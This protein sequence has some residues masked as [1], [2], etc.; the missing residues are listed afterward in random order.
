[1]VRRCPHRERTRQ[2]LGTGRQLLFFTRCTVIAGSPNFTAV[3]E[4]PGVSDD[5]SVV[6]FYGEN[7]QGPGIFASVATP[8]GSW[9]LV[10]V[11]NGWANFYANS[12]IGVTS[13]QGSPQSFTAHLASIQFRT[14]SRLFPAAREALRFRQTT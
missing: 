4:A 1:M 9:T 11:A 3:G 2:K 12:P 13:P 5:G 6:V 8:S 10:T 7:A 14:D